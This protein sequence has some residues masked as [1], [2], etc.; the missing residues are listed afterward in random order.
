LAF[1][2]LPVLFLSAVDK[3]QALNWEGHD[4]WFLDASPFEAFTNQM[5]APLIKPMPMCSERRK[6]RDKNLY[7]QEAIPGQNCIEKSRGPQ[8]Q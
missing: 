1:L 7:E 6:L 2:V 4:D 3:A 8:S 5:P